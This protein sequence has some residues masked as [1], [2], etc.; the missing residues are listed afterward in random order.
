MSQTKRT[1][2]LV[3]DDRAI[4]RVFTRVLEKKG[5]SVTAV[6]T[7]RDGI[8]QIRCARFDAA[9]VDVRLPDMEGTELLPVIME[10][11]PKTVKIVFTGSP[12]L[13][14]LNNG[15][16]KEM[17]AFLI[18]PISPEIILNILDQKIR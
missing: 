4:L 7:G 15:E 17:D 12:D 18:K 9:I 2:L 5:Y 10:K 11:S 13:E 1:I 6:E 8:D 16:R 3:D 14:S